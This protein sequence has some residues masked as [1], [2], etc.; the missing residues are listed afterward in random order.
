MRFAADVPTV[1]V[2][3]PTYNRK[4]LVLE[5]LE[6]V[7]VQTYRDYEVVLVDDGSTDGTQ[8]AVASLGNGIRYLY[9]ENA[10]EA[11]ARNYGLSAARGDIVA[12]LDS[13]DQ[14][15]PELLESEVG[16]LKSHPEVALACARALTS[17]RK[18]KRF[19]PQQEVLTG[20]LFPLL[21]QT[22][23]VNNSTVVARRSC[24]AEAG[25]F[26]EAYLT[27]YD[28]DLWLR[29]ASRYPLAYVGRYLAYCGRGGDNLSKDT[30]RSREAILEIL[31]KNYDPSRIDSAAYHRRVANCCLAVGR[32]FL[33]QGEYDR[34][35]SFFL[36]ARDLTPYRLRPYR[37]LTKAVFRSIKPSRRF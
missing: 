25:G 16:I 4:A 2:I 37:Y 14:W 6:S 13:D 27:Y 28:Y 23:F 7:F 29:I 33:A 15:T 22:N 5:A 8:T 20:D 35:W 12:F 31:R 26:N 10:G 30:S 1:S 24:L 32:A 19:A 36:K 11:R 34:A 18:S 9:Q 3:I 21:F 17:G